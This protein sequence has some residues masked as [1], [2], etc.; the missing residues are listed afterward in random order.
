MFG[1]TGCKAKSKYKK[2]I[3]VRLPEQLLIANYS[4]LLFLQPAYWNLLLCACA[5]IVLGLSM[6][7]LVYK[8]KK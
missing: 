7:F 2:P 3:F 5:F 8:N 1:W 6:C 4:R